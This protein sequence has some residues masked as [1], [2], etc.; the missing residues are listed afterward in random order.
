ML[1]DQS[2]VRSRDTFG[3]AAVPGPEARG[4]NGSAPAGRRLGR[5]SSRTVAPATAEHEA[6]VHRASWSF[7][8]DARSVSE[9]RH[10]VSAQLSDWGLDEQSDVIELL[11]SELVTNTLRHAWGEPTVSLS[12]RDG[13]LHCEIGD[14]NP[15]LPPPYPAPSPGDDETGRGMQ[16]VNLLSG[17]WGSAPTPAGKIV[18]FELPAQPTSAC[19]ELSPAVECRQHQ[20]DG[21]LRT[22]RAA[23]AFSALLPTPS[24]TGRFNERT[25]NGHGQNDDRHRLRDARRGGQDLRHPHEGV[26]NQCRFGRRRQAPRERRT[27]P[28]AQG[29]RPDRL[30]TWCLS[31]FT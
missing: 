2:C 4:G 21:C 6:A 12:V 9:A 15:T 3:G 22:E 17:S 5:G 23:T 14:A 13:T 16:L 10:L 20:R 27:L 29:G 18:W 25:A 28:L 26:H 30:S 19:H 11:V 8:S 7:C 31:V 1:T 24:T